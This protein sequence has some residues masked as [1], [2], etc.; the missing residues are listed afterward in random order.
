MTEKVNELEILK[1]QKIDALVKCLGTMVMIPDYRT[2]PQDLVA[3][4][5][6]A[7]TIQQPI[8]QGAYRDNTLSKL[9]EL[10]S[11]L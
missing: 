3:G 1:L 8:L 4:K 2:N 9:D 7:G 6:F 11:Q 5:Q 10:I